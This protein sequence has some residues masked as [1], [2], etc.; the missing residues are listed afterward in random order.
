MG[1]SACGLAFL[2]MFLFWIGVG[3]NYAI[4][5]HMFF[6][7]AI[8]IFVVT[9]IL[10]LRRATQAEDK[11]FGKPAAPLILCSVL[12]LLTTRIDM[13]PSILNL[14]KVLQF[15]TAVRELSSRGKIS[16]GRGMIA[17]ASE[18]PPNIAYGI[19]IGDLKFPMQIA[20]LILEHQPLPRDE[21]SIAFMPANDPSAPQ[22]CV[23]PAFS[24][25]IAVALDYACIL[26]AHIQI[27]E[28]LEPPEPEERLQ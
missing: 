7:I 19:T 18:W 22:T 14:G 26:E 11:N 21:V 13:Y 9:A 17:L 24:N 1:L 3:S 10:A 12:A 27:G 28:G 6:L 25:Q 4:A 20:S 23:I 5:K 15:Q 16:D 8:L 2:Q